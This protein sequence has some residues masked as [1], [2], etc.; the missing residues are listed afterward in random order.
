MHCKIQNNLNSTNINGFQEP[1]Q[2]LSLKEK[3]NLTYC[4]KKQTNKKP[5]IWIGF[6]FPIFSM[7]NIFFLY[8][9]QCK[10]DTVAE[11]Y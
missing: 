11:S 2:N 7:I 9:L 1:Q 8:Q 5:N 10:E 3:K 6:G 4:N